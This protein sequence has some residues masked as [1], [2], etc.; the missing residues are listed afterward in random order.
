M[1]MHLAGPGFG[2]AWR[3]LEENTAVGL[4]AAL[5]GFHPLCCAWDRVPANSLPVGPVWVLLG[6]WV[7][8]LCVVPCIVLCLQLTAVSKGYI[9]LFNSL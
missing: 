4:Q 7:M 2:E 3:V 1:L 8:L 6:S 5:P 9:H